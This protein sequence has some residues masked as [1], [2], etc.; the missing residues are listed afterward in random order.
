M[1]FLGSTMLWLGY[2]TAYYG[3]TQIQGGNWG[4][5]D[6]TLPSHWP[7]AANIPRDGAGLSGPVVAGASDVNI[8]AVAAAVKKG[9][10]KHA[11]AKAKAHA[12]SLVAAEAKTLARQTDIQTGIRRVATDLQRLLTGGV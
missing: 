8:K 10:K 11:S 9:E 4:F 6:L 12:R 7:G 1:L 3:L 2:A 5:L